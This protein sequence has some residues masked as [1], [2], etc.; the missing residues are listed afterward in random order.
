[1][2]NYKDEVYYGT[3]DGHLRHFSRDYLSDNGEKIDAYWESG[4][5]D[6][7]NDFRR[8][9]SA[10]L[11]LSMKPETGGF[12][13]ITA[14]TD[15]KREFAVYSAKVDGVN[16]VPSAEKV[17][18]KAKKFSYYKLILRNFADDRTVTVVGA[19]LRIR[20]AGKVI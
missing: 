3:S 2:I 20:S 9:Y 19:D 11:W 13:E 17:H 4:A 5:M 1:M 18:L 16:N 6:F 14:E 10:N 12:L 7:G 15:R 8:K